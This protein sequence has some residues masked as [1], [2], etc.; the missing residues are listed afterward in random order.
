METF[1]K[2]LVGLG[3]IAIITGLILW[4]FGDKLTWFGNLPGDIK[5]EGDNVRIYAPITSMIIISIVLSVILS[6]IARFFR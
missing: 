6:V 1:G 5:I 4:F 3:A 2:I